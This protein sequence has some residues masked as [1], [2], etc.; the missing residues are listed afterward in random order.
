VSS[1]AG[2]SVRPPSSV[3]NGRVY[4]F[5]AVLAKAGIVFDHGTD[6]SLAEIYAAAILAARSDA[7]AVLQYGGL[8]SDWLVREGDDPDWGVGVRIDFD[9]GRRFI[10]WSIRLVP[11]G[12]PYI[13][14]DLIKPDRG[15]TVELLRVEHTQD[16]GFD[17]CVTSEVDPELPPWPWSIE[18]CETRLTAALKLMF[19]S[20]VGDPTW[21]DPGQLQP[22][23]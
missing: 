20:V 8:G 15:L 16:R 14:A 10:T 5:L 17:C 9:L 6:L 7:L 19:E 4:E 21:G 12:S 11:D 18:F 1:E 3:A 2:T 22:A 13:T 23:S